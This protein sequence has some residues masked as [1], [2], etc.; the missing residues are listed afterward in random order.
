MLEL[1]FLWHM[2]QPDYRGEDGVM[3]MPWV[4]LHA[5]KDYYEMPW[6]L[7]LHPKLK[8]SFNLTPPLIEQLLL[9]IEKGIEADTFLTLWEKEPKSLSKDERTWLVKLC[10]SSQFDTM[11]AP[12]PRYAQLYRQESYSDAELV[13][14]E[15]LFLLA[16]CG[17]ALRQENETVRSLLEKGHSYDTTDK[18]R[19][20]QALLD[21]L[22]EILPFY[23]R[24]MES[25][26]IALSTTPLNHP[27][28]PLLLDMENARRSNP[29]TTLPEHPLSL[30]DDA[31]LQ[32]DRAIALYR[33]QFGRA[34]VGF[35]PAEGAVDPES[36]ALYRQRGLR[37]IAT[38][39]AILFASLGSDDRSTLYRRH[40]FDGV[41]I[42]FRDHSLSDLIGFTYRYWDAQKAAD[43]F[44]ERLRRIDQT[45][46]DPVV[47]VILDGENAW[48][49]Y[50]RNG[51]E[52]FEALYGALEKA[53]S[54]CRTRTMDEEA[55]EEARELP[56]L[57]PGS[58]I[59]GTFDTWVGHPEKNAAW[60][61]IYQTKRDIGHHL[62][63]LD[64]KVRE[65]IEEHFLAAE[66]SDWFWW[67][68]DDHHTDYSLE[69]DRLFR[70]H[71]IAIYRLAGLPVS[72]LLYRPIVTPGD[73][74]ALFVEPKFPISPTIDGRVSSFFEW[75]GSGRSD[76]S[77]LFS[78]MDRVRG[79]VSTLYWGEDRRHVYLRFDGEMARLEGSLL[80]LYRDDT[81]GTLQIP[82][83]RKGKK[84]GI[85]VALDE[86]VEI[87]LDKKLFGKEGTVLLR[88]EIERE[89]EILQTLPAAGELRID[90]SDDFSE[91]W[92]V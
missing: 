20:L 26:Q 43:D 11:V 72:S 13:E 18:E 33:E 84:N 5:I 64:P 2:H 88:L 75:L 92:F 85:E 74:H 10:R 37:W 50:P 8:A 60:E 24:L 59:Y 45:Q 86:I 17:N 91:N 80:R 70:G 90:L 4:F 28:L 61:L 44:L 41:R 48:E 83:A 68:G 66:C 16:W 55:G 29:R 31:E 73:R 63:S 69:F 53:G 3:K 47:S 9:Y 35:W 27:I 38:D 76:E 49:F 7:S 19:L 34:P 21:F 32:V 54:W 78:T 6:L 46:T 57:H 23:R 15:L 77:R 22:P 71:L 52:F 39:E 14:L 62:D 56:R 81:E 30:A 51:M 82:L 12:L 42:A 40:R 25:G 89:G 36:V 87:A 58:W 79:P 1:S 67:Y 65:E